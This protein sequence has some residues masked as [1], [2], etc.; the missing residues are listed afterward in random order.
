MTFK[1][2]LY[3]LPYGIEVVGEYPPNAKVKYWSVRVRPHPLVNGKISYG[4]IHARRCRVIAA[5]KLGRIIGA[6]EQVHHLNGNREDDRP[7]NIEI[8]SS[9]DHNQIHKRGIPL[10]AETRKKIGLANLK[11][12]SEGRKTSWGAKVTPMLGEKNGQAKL[13]AA[14]AA[15][16]RTSSL[17]DKV[18]AVRFGVSRQNISLIKHGK[19][20]T[21]LA[22]A[23]PASNLLGV[24]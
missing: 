11:A 12:I 10:K 14:D 9:S 13:T 18:L 4:A 21:H 24:A 15:F 1:N 23:E 20:W 8:L 16:I 5:S 17:P 6:K 19:A 2:P 22:G 7:E 3:V